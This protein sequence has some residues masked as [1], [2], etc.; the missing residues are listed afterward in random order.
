MNFPK[1]L[2]HKTP[3]LL[4]RAIKS[5]QE[6]LEVQ[7]LIRN[8]KHVELTQAGAALREEARQILEQVARASNVARGARQRCQR[9]C[10]LLA[11]RNPPA[12][13]P[14][15]APMADDHRH[16]G[17]RAGGFVVPSTL[18]RPRV[19]GVRFVR[20]KGEEVLAPALLVWNPAYCPPALRSFMGYSQR[21]LAAGA[22]RRLRRLAFMYR[23]CLKVAHTT[24]QKTRIQ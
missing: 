17:Q 14:C 16:G 10:H 2:P 23:D 13:C 7:L 21:V 6:G 20:T 1:F 9:D 12:H 15:G 5:L 8:S 19:H 24:A 18:A 11:R 22:A 4:S 3:P